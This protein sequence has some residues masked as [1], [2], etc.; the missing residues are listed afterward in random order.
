MNRKLRMGMIGG[1]IVVF[2]SDSYYL[3]GQIS[4]YIW[5]SAIDGEL[6]RGQTLHFAVDDLT[7][8]SHNIQLQVMD[9][10]GTLSVIPDY[11]V[12]LVMERPDA[13]IFS[14]AVNGESVWAGWSA[15]E[16]NSG[17]T[18][19]FEGGTTSGQSIS[20]YSWVS[21]MDGAISSNAQFDTTTLSN[22]TH[23]IISIVLIFQWHH[24]HSN[25]MCLNNVFQYYN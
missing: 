10:N 8:G 23:I 3:A 17:D 20:E 7:Q 25:P 5:S 14:V 15:I 24:D 21:D 16:A 22:G 1:G 13:A 11:M 2:I 18:V 4:E 9:D 6:G 19:S 12:L